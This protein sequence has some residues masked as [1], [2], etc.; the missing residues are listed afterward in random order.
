MAQTHPV[1]A[2]VGR[3]NVGKSTLFNC[4]TKTRDAI[5]AD[6]PGLTRDRQYG[7]GSFEKHTFIVV[8]T[9][10]IGAEEDTMD[11]LMAR[12]SWQAIYE[13][14]VI[15]FLVN[16]REGLI[17]TDQ[18]IAE[19][20][21]VL[22]KPIFLVMNKIDGLDAHIAASDFHALG[23]G[24][25]IAIAAAHH[26]GINNLLENLL[27]NF[28]PAE[29]EVIEQAGIKIAIVGKPNVGKS[30]LVN[31]ML[32]EERVVVYD[33]PGTTRDSVFIHLERR[34]KHYVL[35]DTAGVRRR[36]RVT[37]VIE[38]FSVI[39]TM[40]A[41]DECNVVIMLIDARENIAEQDL[42]LLGHIIDSGKA[43][44]IAVNKWDGLE[45]EE[46][47]WIKKELQRRLVFVDYAAWHFISALHGSGVGDLFVSV[48]KAYASAMK[49]LSTAKITKI[50]EQI[51]AIHP[52]P[53]VKGKKIK[54]RYAH[55][56]GHNPPIVVI[57]GKRVELLPGSY[58][59]YL[60]NTFRKSL[61][62]IGTP[63]KIELRESM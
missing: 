35:I 26:R 10:G 40:Q 27:A 4:I 41:I 51:V 21:R 19:K 42:K 23:L 47:V 13:S 50:L 46:K 49:S 52:P 59:R 37:D 28:T 22:N 11:N 18:L 32:G 33:E 62:L 45:S 55:I 39:K 12:Q 25:P 31:R 53:L 63:I 61:Q 3:P 58:K 54:L 48:E 24:E 16:A 30:T 36:A 44:V 5:V 60:E 6:R 15:I 38:K 2:I 9:G 56:G 34:G 17:A 14:D 8:D 1:I 20:L 7:Y 29:E 57:H 43:L